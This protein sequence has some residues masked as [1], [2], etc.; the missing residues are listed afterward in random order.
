[1]HPVADKCADVFADA[2]KCVD[3]LGPLLIEIVEPHQRSLDV[4]NRL[5]QRSSR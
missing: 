1:M 2:L 3:A 4:T 5:P